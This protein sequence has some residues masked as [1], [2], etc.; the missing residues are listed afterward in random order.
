MGQSLVGKWQVINQTNCLEKELPNS[1]GSDDTF[2]KEFSTQSGLSPVMMHFGKDGSV[3]R[4]IKIIG[5][6]K[7]AETQ[8]YKFSVDGTT[9]HLSDKKSKTIL[10]IYT[11][12]TLTNDS[13]VYVVLGRECEK[14]TLVRMK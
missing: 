7:P 8:E 14:T 2:L 1:T 6:K 3:K 11:I 10:R 13:L 4:I 12:E 9:I 5:E